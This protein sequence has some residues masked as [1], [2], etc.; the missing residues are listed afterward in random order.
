M[1]S[2]QLAVNRRHDRYCS[3]SAREASR[4]SELS[5]SGSS[6]PGAT[7][8]GFERDSQ[9]RS[10]DFAAERLLGPPLRAGD[11]NRGESHFIFCKPR[12][13]GLLAVAGLSRWFVGLKPGFAGSL[14]NEAPIKNHDPVN[15]RSPTRPQGRA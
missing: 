15:L 4:L 3:P 5:L 12:L 1:N 8:H 13:T 2:V 14:V 11:R 7:E 10:R 9:S 6:G